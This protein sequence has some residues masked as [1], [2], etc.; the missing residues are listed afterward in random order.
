MKQRLLNL[1]ISLD[2]FVFCLL[3][4]GASDPDETLSAAA[5][6]WELQGK[7]MGKLLRPTI[8]LVIWFDRRHCFNS[9]QSEK[10]GKQLPK[11]YR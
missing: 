4:I 5:W 3:T 7:I 8:D 6:R 2:Q 1:L 11:S 9:Y 10:L